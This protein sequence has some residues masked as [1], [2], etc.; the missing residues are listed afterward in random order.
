ME[1]YREWSPT[2]YDRAGLAG[3]REGIADWW[4]VLL[5]N[6][7]SDCIAESNFAAALDT[8]GG[9]SETVEVHRFRHWGVGWFELLLVS[10]DREADARAIADRLAEYP[11]L[12]EDDLSRRELETAAGTWAEC[13]SVRE[14]IQWMRERRC[15]PAESFADLR[16]IVMG[17]SLPQPQD[18]DLSRLIY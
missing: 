8:L 17:D 15:E 5:R 1:R 18:G 14:R 2:P 4:V 12:D 16:S 9:E 3:D 11:V 13:Y 7:D 10:P 6:R